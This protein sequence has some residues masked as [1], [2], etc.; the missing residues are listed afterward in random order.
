MWRRCSSHLF[1]L[2]QDIRLYANNAAAGAIAALA[3]NVA[4]NLTY[5]ASSPRLRDATPASPPSAMRTPSA[6]AWR[7][8]TSTRR[9]RSRTTPQPLTPV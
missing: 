6:Y 5:L 8:S 2:A 9:L 3:A 7:F 4:L 1:S